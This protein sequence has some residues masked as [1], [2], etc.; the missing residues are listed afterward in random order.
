[1]FRLLWFKFFLTTKAL[2]LNILAANDRKRCIFTA[3]NF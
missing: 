3:L 2:R 1:M